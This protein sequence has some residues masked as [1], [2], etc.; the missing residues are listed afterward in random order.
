MRINWTKKLSSV[1]FSTLSVECIRGQYISILKLG[2][3]RHQKQAFTELDPLNVAHWAL[4]CP[5]Q[6]CGGHLR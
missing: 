5:E 4:G 2:P 6:L 3:P 1:T